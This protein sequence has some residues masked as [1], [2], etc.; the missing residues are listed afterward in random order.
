MLAKEIDSVK[1]AK[2]K[3]PE[4]IRAF[5]VDSTKLTTDH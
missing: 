2:E 4:S 3:G 1:I 5:L